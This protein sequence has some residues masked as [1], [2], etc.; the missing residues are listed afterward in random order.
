MPPRGGLLA[1]IAGGAKLKVGQPSN[2]SL[3]AN[4]SVP[5]L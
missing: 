4:P 5:S 1:G 2:F 3:L